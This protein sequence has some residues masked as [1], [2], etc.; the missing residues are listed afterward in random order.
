MFCVHS[1]WFFQGPATAVG[2]KRFYIECVVTETHLLV[3][4]IL[5]GREAW[6]EAFFLPSA[7]SPIL[8]RSHAAHCPFW[9]ASAT[10]LR[11]SVS[12]P[13]QG[14][15][16]LTPEV[17]LLVSKGPQGLSADNKSELGVLRLQLLHDGT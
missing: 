17:V 4:Y 9:F 5:L 11:S 6:I 13:T 7:A 10:V 12:S 16:S 3:V 14:A 15:V 8:F 2:A 1:S